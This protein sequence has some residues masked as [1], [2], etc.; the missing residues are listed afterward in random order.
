[1]SQSSNTQTNDTTEVATFGAGCF[2]CVEAVFEQ[3]QGVTHVQSGYSGGH[4][5]NPTYQQV[6]TGTTGHA[7]VVQITF[8]PKIITYPQLLEVF[9]GTHNPTTLNK[10]GGDVGTQYR[11]VIFYHNPQQKYWSELAIQAAN[12]SGDWDSPIVTE[13]TPA[14]EFY[15]AEDY[16]NNYFNLNGENPY[17]E[18]V[19]VPKIKKF[20]SK[21]NQLL[22]P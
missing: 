13:I 19:I 7:E 15:P 16:H 21:F 14:S 20:K 6:C 5:P 4:I 17:C 8:N 11:S 18:A 22:K 1:M 12:E 3:L 10:Q 2:W 9:F